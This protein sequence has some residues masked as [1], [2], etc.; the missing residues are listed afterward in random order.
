MVCEAL[1]VGNMEAL[2]DSNLLETDAGSLG[3]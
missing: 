3:E 2:E 1:I